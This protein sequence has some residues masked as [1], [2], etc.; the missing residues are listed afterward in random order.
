VT[1]D[2]RRDEATLYDTGELF[3]HISDP[4]RRP[5]LDNDRI[6]VLRRIRDAI[7]AELCDGQ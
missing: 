1:T 7:N 3:A 4:W 2:Y 6:E 5:L